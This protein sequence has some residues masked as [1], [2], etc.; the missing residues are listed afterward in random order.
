MVIRGVAARDQA[1]MPFDE[2]APARKRKRYDVSQNH[3]HHSWHPL[4]ACVPR[5]ML[6]GLGKPKKRMREQ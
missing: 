6:L 4:Q 1:G 3:L 2:S 5:A